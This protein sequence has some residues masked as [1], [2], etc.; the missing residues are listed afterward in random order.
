MDCVLEGRK[1]LLLSDRKNHLG[2]LKE[3]F[4][5][6]RKFHT[7]F[8]I[9]YTVGYYLGGMKQAE[10][11][12]TEKDTIILGTFAMASE[13]FDCREPLDTIVLASP[14]SNIEQAVGR[15]LR[16]EARDRKFTPLVIDLIDEF[17]MFP[18]QGLKRIKFY[19]RNKY[20]MRTFDSN[21][22]EI[23]M[24]KKTKKPKVAA[25]D[26]EFLADSD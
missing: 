13:G 12:K 4:E 26:L 24:P 9:D 18:K 15:I 2:I 22:K 5:K 16:Q 10:L 1:I 3:E 19:Q 11:E 21:G 14:K 8:P 23:E 7:D 17:S 6:Y 25:Q 20:N